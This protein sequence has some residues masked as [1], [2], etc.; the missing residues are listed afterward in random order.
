MI[1][2]FSASTQ[3]LIGL[4]HMMSRD[5]RVIVWGGG[6]RAGKTFLALAY[7][8]MACMKKK[9]I[10]ILI[11]RK[12]FTKLNQT[13]IQTLIN[14]VAPIM[15]IE[16]KFV[17]NKNEHTYTCKATGSH[18]V[19]RG[20]DPKGKENTLGGISLTCAI[21]DEA[22]ELDPDILT[23]I[24]GRLS[25]RLDEN[26]MIGKLIIVS[27]PDRGYLYNEYYKPWKEG[28][29][30]DDVVYVHATMHDNPFLPQSYLDTMTLEEQG[31][32]NYNMFVRGDW[33][34]TLNA[35]D[36][37][38]A[39]T[40]YDLFTNNKE[41]MDPSTDK[42]ISVDPAGLGKDST[43]IV[44]SEGFYIKE[45]IKMQKADTPTV[46]ARVKEL[47]QKHQVPAHNIIVD[48]GALAG[49]ADYLPHCVRYNS[50]GKL[51]EAKDMNYGMLRDQLIF[52]L[53]D[54]V[55]NRK[56]RFAPELQEYC[57]EFTLQAVEHKAENMEQDAKQRV[58]TK[59]VVKK[60]IGKSYSSPDLFDAIYQLMWFALRK[61]T[62]RTMAFTY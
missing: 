2:N 32:R 45:I 4:G 14:E 10:R 15:G 12:E 1:G 58:T 54:M 34:W 16:D 27:N 24:K 25:Y 59:K 61:R 18:I 31:E 19:F 62:Y 9:G 51:L 55:K 28:T 22:S 49:H 60:R 33:E 26:N 39:P 36:L 50:N 17:H 43:A 53:S 21:I 42:L 7:A 6:W 56:I 46:V 23:E 35:N 5:K 3:Q 13:T 44:Y 57:D 8:V 11:G 38:F 41:G 52:K 20:L 40:I 30:P 29:L 37:F 47:K 48:C